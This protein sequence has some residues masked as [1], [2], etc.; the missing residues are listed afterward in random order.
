MTIDISRR[1]MLGVVAASAALGD[2]APKMALAR[3]TGRKGEGLSFI[4]IGDWGRRGEPHQHA[5][6]VQ[7]G[8]VAD[9]EGCAFT[10]ALGDNFYGAGVASVDDRHWEESFNAVYTAPSLQTPWYAVLGNHDY[11][12][13]AQA[14]VD[15][16]RKSKRWTMPERYFTFDGARHGASYVDFFMIDTCPLIDHYMQETG[17]EREHFVQD[18]NP[19]AQLAWL[20]SALGASKAKWKIVSGHHPVFSGGQHGDSED[21]ISKVLPILKRHG[22]KLYL[23]GHDHDMQHIERDGMHFVATGC[24]STVREVQH[25]AGTRFAMS[26]SGLSSYRVTSEAIDLR[27]IDWAGKNVYEATI[28][29]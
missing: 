23:C 1:S 12:G 2:L 10:L 22:V 3:P 13:N 4:A 9:S 7:M 27:F 21:M 5:V 28:P 16:S 19:Q 25:V 8:H 29:A 18:Q 14:Q 15:Y 20:D 24:A 6:G 26:T 17:P 11:K